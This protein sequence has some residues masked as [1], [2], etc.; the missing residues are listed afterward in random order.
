LDGYDPGIL[1][2]TTMI[3]VKVINIGRSKAILLPDQYRVAADVAYLKKTSH[4]FI[5]TFD[6]PW[7][8]FKEGIA[9]LSSETFSR[10]RRQPLKQWRK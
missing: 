9:E 7:E 1:N 2:Q 6:D 8:V 3:P 10:R 5:I 4:G